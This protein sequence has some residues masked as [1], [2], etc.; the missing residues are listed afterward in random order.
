MRH[1]SKYK[2][3]TYSTTP[4]FEAHVPEDYPLSDV[5]LASRRFHDLPPRLRE[6]S[7]LAKRWAVRNYPYPAGIQGIE[8]YYDDQ[9]YELDT[10]T[11]ERMSDA[12][13]NEEW[14]KVLD[15]VKRNVVDIP[16][17]PGGFADPDTWDRPPEPEEEDPDADQGI[18]EK[19]LLE[20]IRLNGRERV[21]KEHGIHPDVS[22]STPSD[23][24]LA[25]AILDV[26]GS[27]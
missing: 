23:T 16:L 5:M 2:L 3:N 9:G 8:E 12:V 27:R 26:I 7:A 17:P 22:A 6:L 11:G 13:L 20:D 10:R 19:Q 14:G 18:T 1:Y 24:S 15:K 4:Y 21:V 25:R